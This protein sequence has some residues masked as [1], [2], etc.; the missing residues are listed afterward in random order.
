MIMWHTGIKQRIPPLKFQLPCD[1]IW[2]IKSQYPIFFFQKKF[3]K[4]KIMGREAK[5]ILEKIQNG[6]I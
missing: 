2:Y 4:N 3:K 5:G 6:I 1:E